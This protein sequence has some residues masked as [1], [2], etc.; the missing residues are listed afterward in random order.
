MNALVISGNNRELYLP[1]IFKTFPARFD[2]QNSLTPSHCNISSVI[3][4]FPEE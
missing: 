3:N 4:S 1:L 2:E